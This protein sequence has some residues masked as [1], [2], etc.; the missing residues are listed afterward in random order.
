M[1]GSLEDC[2]DTKPPKHYVEKLKSS[3]GEATR[4]NVAYYRKNNLPRPE[5][6]AGF[7]TCKI[8]TI[9]SVNM[10]MKVQS[11]TIIQHSNLSPI[12]ITHKNLTQ[13]APSCAVDKWVPISALPFDIK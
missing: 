5:R 8:G 7:L 12:I 1:E 13:S 2:K 10:A 6:A 4:Q 3:A 9:P 11:F